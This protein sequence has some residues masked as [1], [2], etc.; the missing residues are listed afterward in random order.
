M[1]DKFY[2]GRRRCIHYVLVSENQK[3]VHLGMRWDEET[4]D[5]HDDDDDTD[6][7]HNYIILFASGQ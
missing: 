2:Y 7:I 1:K 3:I 6:E 5:A 4:D